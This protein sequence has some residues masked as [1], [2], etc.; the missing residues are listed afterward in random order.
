M[1]GDSV[2]NDDVLRDPKAK[3]AFILGYA[4]AQAERIKA[5]GLC[6]ESTVNELWSELL[7]GALAGYDVNVKR[8]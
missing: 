1:S 2:L 6:P 5:D 7:T 4:L 8:R 3:A